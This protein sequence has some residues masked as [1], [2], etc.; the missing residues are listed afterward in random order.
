MSTTVTARVV[1]TR[2]MVGIAHMQVC[3]VADATDE[4]ILDV[5]NREN[6][7]GTTGGWQR[8]CRH[9]ADEIDFWG[10]GKAP[11]ACQDDPTRIHLLVAC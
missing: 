4:E 9:E 8:V 6:P 5:C 3:A 10:W 1:V 7:A 2:A 11:V